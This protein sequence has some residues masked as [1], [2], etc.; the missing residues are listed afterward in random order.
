[1]VIVQT[2]WWN[3]TY[4]FA[5][6][7]V[8]GGKWATHAKRRFTDYKRFGR[9]SGN[10]SFRVKRFFLKRKRLENLICQPQTKPSL[11]LIVLRSSINPILGNL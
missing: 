9:K 3:K 4:S 10:M 1:M 7:V 2:F 6:I 11:N 8:S 5:I